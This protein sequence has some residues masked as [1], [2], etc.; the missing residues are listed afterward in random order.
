[1]TVAWGQLVGKWITR[2]CK[3]RG[4][5]ADQRESDQR[6]Q[7]K[8]TGGSQSFNNVRHRGLSARRHSVLTTREGDVGRWTKESSNEDRQNIR[9]SD[10]CLVPP[11]ART[12]EFLSSDYVAVRRSAS[13]E[14]IGW[15]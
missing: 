12:P 3:R 8:K 2:P 11:A 5:G 7:G 1:M 15:V 9:G 4:S 13:E 10:A 6:L 14:V